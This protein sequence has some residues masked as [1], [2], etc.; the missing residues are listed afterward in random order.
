MCSYVMQKAKRQKNTKETIGVNYATKSKEA[1][2]NI[3]TSKG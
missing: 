3:N 2:Y 1:G